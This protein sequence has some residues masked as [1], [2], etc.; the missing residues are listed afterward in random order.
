[1]KVKTIITILYL[2]FE[3]SLSN[4]FAATT[5]I[6]PSIDNTMAEDFSNNS[7]G[8]CDSIFSGTTDNNVARRALMQFDIATAIPPGSTINR[9]TLT[10]NVTRGSNHPDAVMTIHPVTLAWAEAA[11]GV[12][13]NGCGTRGGGQG[14]PAV[15]GAATWLSAMHNQTL[16]GSPGGDFGVA[17]SGSTIVN[18]ITPVWD[19]AAAGNGA[20][21]SDVQSWLDSP[22]ANYGWILIG[23]EASPTTSRRFDSTEGSAAPALVVDFTPTGDVEACCQTD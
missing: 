4:S 23:D 13:P 10:M 8:D 16:W 12:T 1:M 2:L 6:N 17:A 7:S 9:V 18:N 19:S 20:M 14:E 22:A 11:T 5:I 15:T 3:L 21:V